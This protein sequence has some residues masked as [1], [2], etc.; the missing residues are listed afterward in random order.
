MAGVS[1]SRD[2]EV[3]KRKYLQNGNRY[4]EKQKYKEAYIMYRNALK[5]DP[6]YSEAYYRVGL[7]ELRMCKAIDAL[8]DFRRAI[9]TDPHFTIPD[10][11]V[12]AGNILLMGYLV[13]EDHPAQSAR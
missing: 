8:R 4:F 9:D 7:T 11:R 3:V 1:C 5:K 6:R 2:P 13:R 10:A 12:Q